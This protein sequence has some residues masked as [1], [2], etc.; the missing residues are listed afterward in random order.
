MNYFEQGNIHYLTKE[1]EQ[2]L[3][4]YLKANKEH[5]NNIVLHHNI[6]I[7]LCQ[8]NRAEE[9]LPY[10]DLPCSV[11]YVESWISRGTALR[12]VGRYKETLV[13]FATAFALDPLHA[14][15]YSNYGNTLREFGFPNLGI[16]FLK[17]A[18][19]LKPG[20]VNYELNE[21][22]CHLMN[23]DLIE[24]WKKYNARWWY[25]SDTCFKPQLPGPEYDGTQDI[26]SKVVM[27]YHEQ[28]FGDNIQFIR[29]VKLLQDRGAIV[30]IVTKPQLLDLFKF[31]FPSCR[32]LASDDTIPPYHYHVPL[33]DLP[34]CF[35]TTIDTIPHRDPYLTVPDE[36]KRQWA[37]KLGPKN[38]KRIGILWSPNKVAFISRFRKI[39]LEQLLSIVDQ[40]F[41][42]ISLSYEVS[43]QALDLLSKYNVRTFHE[44]ISGFYETAGLISQLDLVISIDTVIPH[45][46]GALGIPTW[47]ML[48]DYGCDWRWFMNRVDSPF[49]NCLRLFRQQGD[50]KWD[51]VLDSIQKELINLG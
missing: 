38:K 11:N 28:G 3:E 30:I 16:P 2:A 19:E 1:Y 44:D 51:S 24:G 27:V 46:S 47:V 14:T 36:L 40:K 15:A 45:L 43:Q 31:N 26:N 50:G 13:T 22:V 37:D 35:N 7:V 23:E 29:Y 25:Q 9:A 39:E 21:A 10:F 4:C 32:V 49:Y 48:T 20:D 17:I 8:L 18:Q 5:P 42:F 33:M 12:A 41:E 6:G 34:K